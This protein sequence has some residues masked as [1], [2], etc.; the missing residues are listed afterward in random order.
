MRGRRVHLLRLLL[1]VACACSALFVT[2]LA[3][4]QE[5]PTA[6]A[7]TAA[8]PVTTTAILTAAP[9]LTAAQPSTAT[10]SPEPANP[11]DGLL[12]PLP[13]TPMAEYTTSFA[14][15]ECPFTAPANQQIICGEFEAPKNGRSR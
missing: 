6:P 11:L 12:D 14:E 1:P 13:A 2:G 15:V 4:A 5:T 7:A 9:T 8:A 10:A 3:H